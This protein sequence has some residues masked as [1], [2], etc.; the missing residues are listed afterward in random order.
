MSLTETLYFIE[1]ESVDVRF[2][3]TNADTRSNWSRARR[4]AGAN[5]T[6]QI[7]EIPLAELRAVGRDL[8]P[9]E[10]ARFFGVR[11]LSSSA[12]SRIEAAANIP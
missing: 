9:V 6:R 4:P 7:E 3:W 12:R 5:D 1:T 11:R 10:A 8:D 2:I